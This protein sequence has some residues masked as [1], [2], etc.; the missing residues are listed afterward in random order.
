MNDRRRCVAAIAVAIAL[1][2]APIVVVIWPAITDPKG[3]RW[4]FLA[5]F[6]AIVAVSWTFGGLATWFVRQRGK[7]FQARSRKPPRAVDVAAYICIYFGSAA[8]VAYVLL[9]EHAFADVFGLAGTLLLVCGSL[10]LN[11]VLAATPNLMAK[12]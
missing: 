1:V 7:A 6:A 9:R 11:F 3:P 2:L 8:C 12:M 5:V 4:K 10:I